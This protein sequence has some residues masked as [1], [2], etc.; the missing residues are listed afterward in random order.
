MEPVLAIGFNKTHFGSP[1]YIP[2]NPLLPESPD[3]SR[4]K[5]NTEKIYRDAAE[6]VNSITGG[7]E[8]IKGKV[9]ISPD[10]MKYAVEYWAGGVARFFNRSMDVGYRAMDDV[11]GNEALLKDYPI[12]RYFAG[13]PEG[14]QD[15]LEYYENIRRLDQILAEEESLSADDIDDFRRRFGNAA[16][17]G[18]LYKETQK[19]LRALRKKKKEIEKL[20]GNPTRS[21]EQIQKLEE[22]MD[23]L[24]DKFN[25]RY[26]EATK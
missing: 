8:N 23:L 2:D 21:Y 19:K 14:F 6:L 26:R 12:L 16:K 13:E 10:V 1:I 24:F 17:L 22:Q 3:S 4:A 9:D 5:R 15:K 25:Q 18:P 20:Q 7:T 11:N